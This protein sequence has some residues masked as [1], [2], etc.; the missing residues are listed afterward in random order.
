MQDSGVRER[1]ILMQDEHGLPVVR[2]PVRM[3]ADRTPLTSA[4]GYGEHT[5]AVLRMAGFDEAEIAA[6]RQQSAVA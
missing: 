1:G 4:P 3:D 5:D 2:T 6:L